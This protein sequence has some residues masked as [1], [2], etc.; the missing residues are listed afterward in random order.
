MGISWAFSEG[1][2]GLIEIIQLGYQAS[3]LCFEFDF[4]AAGADP[5]ELRLVSCS[6]CCALRMAFL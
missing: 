1:L 4:S 2:K 6:A 3:Q 5:F